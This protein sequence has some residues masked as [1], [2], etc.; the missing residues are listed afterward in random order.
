MGWNNV[1]PSNQN[2]ELLADLEENSRF[3]FV[4]SYFV[5]AENKKIQFD[6]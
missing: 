5:E 2:S 1:Y 4:H 3:Y 6:L